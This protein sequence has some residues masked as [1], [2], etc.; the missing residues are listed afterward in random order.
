[1]LESLQQL[2]PR[3]E[4]LPVLGELAVIWIA[5][6]L[7]LRFLERT[8]GAGAM[9]GLLVLVVVLLLGLRALGTSESFSRLRYVSEAMVQFVAILA[10]VV[11][12][13]EI[14]QGMVRIGQALS[15]RGRR[16][17][18]EMIA[19]AVED[20]VRTLSKGRIGAIMVIERNVSLEGMAANGVT[21]DA[22][23]DARLLES[24]FWPN[25][26]LH[27]LAVVIRGNRIA[28]ASV[29]LPLAE[30]GSLSSAMGSRHRAA[31]GATLD[32]DALV[33]VVSEETGKVVIAEGGKLGDPI[34][35]DSFHDELVRRLS[36]DV[37]EAAGA[38]EEAT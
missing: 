15:R 28:A 14:R 21:V 1:M 26:P 18:I 22:V 11:F 38:R 33:V 32:S 29:E 4:F 31:V 35:L 9:K 37:A 19:D 2:I 6:W 5:V 34:P 36:A 20:A 8:R 23:L 7:C 30:T 24:L 3:G 16:A 17:G 25:S 12:Q 10:I 13:P 27:D